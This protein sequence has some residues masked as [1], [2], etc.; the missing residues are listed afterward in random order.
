[1]ID[2][3]E[4]K[5][6]DDAQQIAALDRSFT[7]DSIYTVHC[8]GDQMALRLDTL[9][10]PLTKR[11]PLDDLDMQDRPWEF[12]AVAIAGGHICGFIAAGYQGW[13]RRLTIWHLYVANSHRKRGIAR[14]LLHRANDYGASRSALNM[15][16][17]TSS[18]NV[19]GVKAYRR[20]GFEL[21]G[22]D[23]TLYLGTS[24]ATET[25]LFFARPISPRCVPGDGH[26]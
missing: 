12:A 13:N 2:V 10:T 17:E 14:L 15:W 18:L 19:P 7:T 25:A 20:L 21:C 3:R 16:V 6:P 4:A 22:I 24:A 26:K 1:M 11:F 5:L 23:T 8:H 9:S